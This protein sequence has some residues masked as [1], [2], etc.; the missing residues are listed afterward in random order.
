MIARPTFPDLEPEDLDDDDTEDVGVYDPGDEPMPP[1]GPVFERH[2]AIAPIHNRPFLLVEH[3]TYRCPHMPSQAVYVVDEPRTRDP[4][5]WRAKLGAVAF[6]MTSFA[7]WADD[8][9]G[10]RT[11]LGSWTATDEIRATGTGTPDEVAVRLPDGRVF[12][13]VLS[14][15]MVAGKVTYDVPLASWAKR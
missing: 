3:G 11:R 2:P 9:M 10:A 6:S 8:T 7:C 15:R 1:L 4:A 5:F 13:A 12:K 14:P